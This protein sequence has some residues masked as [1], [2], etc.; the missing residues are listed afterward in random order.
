M[1]KKALLIAYHFPPVQVSSGLQ[2]TLA[3]CKYLRGRG[4]ESV[5]LSASPR[6]YEKTSEDQLKDIP[7]GM[8]V[9]RAFA[10][11]TAK[12]LS[13][14]GRYSNLMALPDRWASW[15]IGGVIAG[16]WAIWK[17]RPKVIWSTYPIATAHLIGLTLHR[18]TGIPWVA[19]FRDSMTEDSYPREPLRRKV[20]LWIERKAV[21][22][23]T[24]AVFTTPGAV[25]MYRERYPEIP[26]D[27]W[28]LIA[29]GYNDE[30]IAE[31]EPETHGQQQRQPAAPLVLVHSGVIYPS[32]RDPSALFQALSE[33][34]QAGDISKQ[35]L[36]I[37]F[38]ASGH[39]SLF[40]PML[41]EWGIDDLVQLKPSI[42]YR[43]ALKEMFAADGLL[44]LQAANC[45][46][47]IPAKIYEYFRARKPILAL[48]DITGDT[49]A[50]LLEAG[51]DDIAA[52]DNPEQ[53]KSRLL[54]FLSAIAEGEATLPSDEVVTKY[55]RE[56][57]STELANIF[58]SVADQKS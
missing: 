16:L 14:K 23:C 48:T 19:D 58:D 4:W 13:V 21:K 2:R 28:A 49:A 32:E 26:E 39:D 54:A 52:L 51:L 11:D 12:H 56:Y 38:R 10:L 29:N 50:T 33:L 36:Q 6:A 44:V 18:L 34:K 30:I 42:P 15:W 47:Q 31:V 46:H 53:I 7:E 37:L 9:K 5:I 40:E 20:F 55:S 24:K 17:H 1:V 35:R 43:Q 27:R 22:H 3:F 57:G 25:R 45:N 41:R 8:T